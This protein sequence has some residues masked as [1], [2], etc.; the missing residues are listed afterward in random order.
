[1]DSRLRGNDT[2]TATIFNLPYNAFPLDFPLLSSMKRLLLILFISVSNV[3]H[4]FAADQYL[5]YKG[6]DYGSQAIFSPLTVIISGGFDVLQFNDQTN[7]LARLQI[8]HGLS[9]VLDNVVNPK[10][11]IDQYGWL[12]FFSSEIFPLGLSRDSYQYVPNYTLHLIGG[13]MTYAATV[14][15]F[16]YHN[17]RYP[18]MLS[19]ITLTV[20]HLLNEAV[21][22]NR[23]T[24]PNV[25]PIADLYIFDPLGC[26]LFSFPRVSKFFSET[27][28]MNDWSPPTLITPDTYQIYNNGQ[29]FSF[30]YDVPKLDRWRLF[31]LAGTEGMWGLSYRL[32]K[33]DDFTASFGLA[34]HKLDEVQMP[35]G[36]R[37]LI[38]RVIYTGGIFYDRNGSLLSS[39]IFGGARGYAARLNVF[40]G[41]V[42][43][44]SFSPGFAL[45]MQHNGSMMA[46]ISVRWSPIGLAGRFN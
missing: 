15:W 31:Y 11:A 16:Q 45:L 22:N 8:G 19:G 2:P 21:E 3:G 34:A 7:D 14:E 38:G 17:Y 12:E 23:F 41:I 4:S 29:K 35:N 20:Q 1:M 36:A 43:V 25:D 24:G 46:G 5:F 39:L 42:K 30:K 10:R 37:K 13:G 27:M 40:P 44:R 26:V 9:N 6:Y 18:R 33:T 32:T 28:H